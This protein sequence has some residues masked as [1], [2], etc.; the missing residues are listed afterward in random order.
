MSSVCCIAAVCCVMIC[1]AGSYT[2]GQQ[3]TAWV[4]PGNILRHTTFRHIRN[5][6]SHGVQPIWVNA[7]Y[8]GTTP[9]SI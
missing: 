1:D 9:H 6:G 4:N 2:C 5:T 7:V 3:A 8:L